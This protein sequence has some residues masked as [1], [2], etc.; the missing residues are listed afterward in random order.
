MGVKE[1]EMK[2]ISLGNNSFMEKIGGKSIEI[3]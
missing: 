2:N 1:R 3:I